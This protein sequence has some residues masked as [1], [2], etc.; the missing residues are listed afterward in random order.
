MRGYSNRH[1][2]KQKAGLA[3]G[4]LVLSDT[5]STVDALK[6]SFSRK[7]VLFH[8]F[9]KKVLLI[10]LGKSFFTCTIL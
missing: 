4:G 6:E 2:V 7:L 8:G 5:S 9:S 3:D 1:L 10:N